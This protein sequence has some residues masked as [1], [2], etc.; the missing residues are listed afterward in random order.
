M[1]ISQST[2]AKETAKFVENGFILISVGVLY[3]IAT[4]YALLRTVLIVP[5]KFLLYN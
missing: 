2:A 5:V 4:I 3:E 1:H